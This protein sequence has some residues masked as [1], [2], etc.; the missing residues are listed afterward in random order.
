VTYTPTSSSAG[1]MSLASG[2]HQSSVN[3]DNRQTE[4]SSGSQRD[5]NGYNG[6]ERW[7]EEQASDQPWNGFAG[8]EKTD[9]K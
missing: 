9:N 8:Q 1:T 7:Y 3:G 4:A 6:M 5:G 2:T